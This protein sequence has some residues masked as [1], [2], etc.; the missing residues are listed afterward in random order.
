[1]GQRGIF[2]LWIK[3]IGVWSLLMAVISSAHL[4]FQ[5]SVALYE[6]EVP[7][8]RHPWSW[9]LYSI[10]R[11]AWVHFYIGLVLISFSEPLS[12]LLVRSWARAG[13]EIV[14]AGPLPARAIMRYAWRAAVIYL[15]LTTML[16]AVISIVALLLVHEQF[17][18]FDGFDRI[19]TLLHSFGCLLYLVLLLVM[20][21]M[22]KI[23]FWL[24]PSKN[25]QGNAE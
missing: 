14:V 20:L 6:S 3:A 18:P 21:A 12:S 25:S 15:L 13:T 4:W 1:M 23:P 22:W 19:V 17:G 7:F 8:T 10:S 9:L 5:W 24:N 16:Q 11:T 2:N